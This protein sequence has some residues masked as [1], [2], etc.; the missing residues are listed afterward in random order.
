MEGD[1][2]AGRKFGSGTLSKSG[3][4]GGR[5]DSREERE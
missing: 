2:E 4:W 5:R 3:E 1:W